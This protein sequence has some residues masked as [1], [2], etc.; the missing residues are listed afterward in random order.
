MPPDKGFLY[1]RRLTKDFITI[2]G[3]SV[4]ESDG[5]DSGPVC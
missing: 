2:V 5:E 1:D 3:G 4:V